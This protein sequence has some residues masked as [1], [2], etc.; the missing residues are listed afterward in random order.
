M[1]P[2]LTFAAQTQ[3]AAPTGLRVHRE[4]RKAVLRLEV[5]QR[6]G[7]DGLEQ[8]LRPH[9]RRGGCLGAGVGLRALLVAHGFDVA[10]T[11][12]SPARN[13]LILGARGVPCPFV[14]WHLGEKRHTH[15]LGVT[16]KPGLFGTQTLCGSRKTHSSR[17]L[18]IDERSVR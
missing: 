11:A 3:R 10:P 9:G 2:N 13:L 6:P 8:G 7:P 16:E 17:P 12:H 4:G 14:L 15:A 1:A 18:T 5:G